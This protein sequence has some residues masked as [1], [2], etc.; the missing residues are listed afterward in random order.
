[1][2]TAYGTGLGIDHVGQVA[3]RQLAGTGRVIGVDMTD[4][5]REKAERLRDRELARAAA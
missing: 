2:A 5:Q 4:A 3:A 1:M